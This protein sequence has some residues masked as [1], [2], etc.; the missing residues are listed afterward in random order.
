MG[1]LIWW[2]NIIHT[3]LTKLKNNLRLKTIVLHGNKLDEKVHANKSSKYAIKG[4]LTTILG[5]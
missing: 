1:N 3:F 2:S 5:S 4:K